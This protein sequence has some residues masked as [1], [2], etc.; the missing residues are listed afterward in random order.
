VY[1]RTDLDPLSWH[2]VSTDAALNKLI[3]D[4][5][6]EVY[7]NKCINFAE[8][9]SSTLKNYIGQIINKPFA[10]IHIIFYNYIRSLITNYKAALRKLL[11]TASSNKWIESVRLIYKEHIDNIKIPDVLSTS[12]TVQNFN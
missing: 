4:K 6:N 2:S 12:P 10:E 5:A 11:N 1:Y 3:T 8:S 7:I 9:I